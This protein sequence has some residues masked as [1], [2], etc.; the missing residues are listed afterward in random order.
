MGK[1]KRYERGGKRQPLSIKA[2]P[3]SICQLSAFLCAL[4]LLQFLWAPLE[5]R[6]SGRQVQLLK[7]ATP[8]VQKNLAKTLTFS[9]SGT[10]EATFN[11]TIGQAGKISVTATWSG[12]ATSLSLILNGPGQTQYYA[13]RD[14]GSPLSLEY[15]LASE[16]LQKGNSW[17]ISLVSFKAEVTAQGQIT[18]HLPLGSSVSQLSGQ[19]TASAQKPAATAVTG[20]PAATTSGTASSEK[21]GTSTSKTTTTATPKPSLKDLLSKKKTETQPVI[22]AEAQEDLSAA[23]KNIEAGIERI[24]RQSSLGPVVIPLFFKYLEELSDNP[25]L[26]RE[27]FRD[28][29][30][31]TARDESELARRLQSPVRAYK[32]IPRE[33]KARYLH[34]A[35]V[36]LK[37]GDRIE[38]RTLG[39]EVI[40]KINPGLEGRVKQVVRESFSGRYLLTKEQVLAGQ[41]ITPVAGMSRLSA[42]KKTVRT[43]VQAGQPQAQAASTILP[44]LSSRPTE[45][46]LNNLKQALEKAG[47]TIPATLTRGSLVHELL[48]ASGASDALRQIDGRKFETDYYRYLVT[49]DWFRCLDKNERSDDEP[50]FGVLT[51]LPQFDPG[52]TNYFKFLK[53]GCLNRTDSYVT[54][55]Y[56]DVKKNT[57]HGLKGDDRVI[58]DCL[59]FN[60]PASFT[61]DLWE[62]DFSKGAVADGLRAAAID[63]M[64]KIKNDLQ[65]AVLSQIQSYIAD[66]ILSSSG[67]SSSAAMQLLNQIFSGSLGFADFQ[68]LL[69]NLYSG[70][71]FDASWYL[72]YFLFSGGDLMQTLAMVGGGSTVVGAVLLGLAIVGPAFSDMISAF[73]S[74]DVNTGLINL[75]KIITVVPL[76]VDFFGS[77]VRSLINLFYMIMA[78]VDPDDHL[79]QKTVVIQQS[80]ANWHNDAKDGDWASGNLMGAMP[81]NEADSYFARRGYGPTRFNSSFIENNLF[82]VPG[83]TIKGGDAEYA[84]YYEVFREKAGGRTTF[85]F[86]FPEKPDLNLKKIIYQSKSSPAAWWRNVLKVSVMS[87]NTQQTPLVFITDKKAGKT[88]SNAETGNILEIEENPGAGYEIWVMKLSP[89]EMAGYLSIYEGPEIAVHCQEA[90]ANG[91]S[92][93]GT[94]PSSGRTQLK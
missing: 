16:L 25:R 18:F 72:I 39:R 85:G 15:D 94:P 5:A 11:L 59:T 31:K 29:A 41:K 7:K 46:E 13:R 61:I 24:T 68:S 62:E 54:R 90:K 1:V 83:F 65:A 49:L 58:F 34:P 89:G 33:F 4:F 73:S 21:I 63:I 53:D 3:E 35:L 74:G 80:S 43:S 12:S 50:Y 52:D 14:G 79:G 28:S 91:G 84:V 76:L 42:Q 93:A 55:T 88:Y 77:I 37:K 92:G 48:K 71:A 51:T 6:A 2:F 27:F 20:T 22:P 10:G 44:R 75:F 78:L 19:P 23:Q 66:A 38:L 81:V 69:F 26:V 67:L 56:G 9:I 8:L 86:Y 87:I 45:A 47:A 17:R 70:R 40:Q 64:M 57:D 60:S 30:H 36:D 32:Q 82:W